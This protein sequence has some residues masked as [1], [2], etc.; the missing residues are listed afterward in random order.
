[1]KFFIDIKLPA[2]VNSEEKEE[3]EKIQI[4]IFEILTQ[5]IKKFCGNNRLRTHY[6]GIAIWEAIY[7][8]T[9]H[10]G[11]T[12]FLEVN[13]GIGISRHQKKLIFLINDNGNFYRLPLI[14]EVI[15]KKDLE[16][17]RNFKPHD[18]SGGYG[19]EIIFESKPKIKILNGTLCLIWEK[20]RN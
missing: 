4:K 8:S 18:K 9:L 5:M 3:K 15:K 12:E 2:T 6:I 1:M 10:G 11:T 17:L 20:A 7:N 14:K 19:F 13:I 16:K